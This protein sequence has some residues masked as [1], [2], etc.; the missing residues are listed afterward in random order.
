M[1]GEIAALRALRHSLDAGGFL[2][3][4]CVLV[5]LVLLVVRLLREGGRVSAALGTSLALAALSVSLAGIAELTLFGSEGLGATQRLE[6]D[7]VDG[8]RGWS[9][10]AWRPVV[11]NVTLFVPLGASLGALGCRRRRLGLLLLAAAV[12]VGVETFQW[13]FPTGRIA[14][15]ADVLAN[16]VGAGLGMALVRSTGACRASDRAA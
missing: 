11:D 3:A 6:L 9:G 12:S 8:A 2:L 5:T 14:N 13:W 4:V 7:P 10:F 15:S 16:I 1:P